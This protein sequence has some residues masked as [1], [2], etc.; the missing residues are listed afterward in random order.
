MA[1]GSNTSRDTLPPYYSAHVCPAL[2][3]NRTRTQ[4]NGTRTRT[5]LG[6]ESGNDFRTGCD[7]ISELDGFSQMVEVSANR[8]EYEYE[9]RDAE[10]ETGPSER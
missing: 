7:G 10:Y 3:P 1:S 5:R 6:L 8:I 9:Y 4:C 2:F